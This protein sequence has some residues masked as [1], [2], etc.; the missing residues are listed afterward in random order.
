MWIRHFAPELLFLDVKPGQGRSLKT[1]AFWAI[2]VMLLSLLACLPLTPQVESASAVSSSK[3]YLSM[4]INHAYCGRH[5][6]ELSVTEELGPYRVA[7]MDGKPISSFVGVRTGSLDKYCDSSFYSTVMNEISI[8][9]LEG[10]LLQL[11]PDINMEQL[12]TILAS[13]RVVLIGFFGFVLLR[14]GASI[15]LTFFVCISA[16]YLTLFLGRDGLFSQYPFFVPATLCYV[17]GCATLADWLTRRHWLLSL[18]LAALLGFAA[19]FNGNLR[20]T[21]YPMMIIVFILVLVDFLR[22]NGINPRHLA[23]SVA[24]VT[25]F[26]T[27]LVAFES[28]YISPMR[29]VEG[30]SNLAHH[31]IAH[32]LVL[33]LARPPSALAYREGIQWLDS[34]GAKLAQK[35]DPSA[36]YMS[37]T[38]EAALLTYYAKLWFYYPG[39]MAQLYFSKWT[40]T[41]ERTI[42][43]IRG[44]GGGIYPWQSKNGAAPGLAILPISFLSKLVG[45]PQV[46]LMVAVASLFFSL[47][48]NA[49]AAVI[50]SALST[51][52]FLG[53]IEAA[54]I[55]AETNLWYNGLVI[56]I[57]LWL[58][59]LAY[60]LL[61]E[62]LLLLQKN[63]PIFD[64]RGKK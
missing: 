10:Y 26:S 57:T 42:D 48:L 61:L 16:H 5:Y 52:S 17:A 14:S 27:T 19:A 12:A 30:V 22:R 13:I 46:F 25:S 44:S 50:L 34:E 53:Y 6:T 63:W 20:T 2:A 39:E 59:L 51:I 64:S 55:L 29:D 41:G 11:V 1:S 3:E 58:G 49:R 31:T 15:V 62:L 35:I 40:I 47:Q 36:D 28:Q 4:A 21:L 60:Q 54:V 56:M 38:Y 23:V 45:L 24:L 8:S 37:S 32:P 9:I 33:G 7:D 43:M 18:G